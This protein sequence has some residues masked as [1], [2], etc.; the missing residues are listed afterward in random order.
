MLVG[1][2]VVESTVWVV[3]ESVDCAELD[4]LDPDVASEGEAVLDADSVLVTAKVE[5]LS[6][7]ADVTDD[8]DADVLA[9]VSVIVGEVDEACWLAV[10]EDV[11]LISVGVVCE[12]K[13][14]D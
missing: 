13:V 1:G 14:V 10:G 11:V 3:R 7:P 5:V 8:V 4:T 12:I 2:A 6:L 9:L